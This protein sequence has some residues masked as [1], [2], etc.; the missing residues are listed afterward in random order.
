MGQR[1]TIQYSVDLDDLES[2]VGKMIK[3][4]AEK[5]EAC[6]ED[7]GETVG[8]ANTTPT[9]TLEMIEKLLNFR[10]ELVSVDNTLIDISNIISSFLRYKLEPEKAP[11]PEQ[12]ADTTDQ[13]MPSEVKEPAIE[14]IEELIGDFNIKVNEITD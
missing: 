9:L 14:R 4:A 5:L 7:L 1:V 6:A 3:C 10:E 8:L 13:E 11:P 2:E 12:Y